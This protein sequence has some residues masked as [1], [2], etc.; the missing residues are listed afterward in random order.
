MH[1]VKYLWIIRGF[2]SKLTFKHFGN[3]S[4][5]GKPLYI[6]GKKRISVGTRTRIFP[7]LSSRMATWCIRAL[8]SIMNREAGTPLP[9]TSPMIRQRWSSSIWKK[10]YRSPPTSRI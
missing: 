6:E 9:D 1:P 3:M 4:Y 5:M 2:F 7:G 8:P 10:S